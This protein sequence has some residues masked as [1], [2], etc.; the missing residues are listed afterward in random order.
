MECCKRNRLLI[1]DDEDAILVAMREY[2]SMRGFDVD[3]ARQGKRALALLEQSR[4]A[5][6]IADLRLKGSHSTEGF[7][8]A[9]EVRDRWPRTRVVL[10]TAYGS[11][12][13]EREARK[14]GVDALLYKPHPLP[15]LAAIVLDLCPPSRTRT[16]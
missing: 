13:I 2:F 9:D 11:P 14:H 3:C 7:E 6:V 16:P 4:Y 1:V 10:L 15:D 5:V 8:V 12:R